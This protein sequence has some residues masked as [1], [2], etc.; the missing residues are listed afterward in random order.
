MNKISNIEQKLAAEVLTSRDVS[1]T[2]RLYRE[3]HFF[4]ICQIHS[5]S[6]HTNIEYY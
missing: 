3:G 4:V 5:L 1:G 6:T 2:V